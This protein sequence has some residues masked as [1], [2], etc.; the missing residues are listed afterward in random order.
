MLS[1]F[2]MLRLIA[3]IRIGMV[4]RLDRLSAVS[5]GGH[6][7]GWLRPGLW[8]AR[9]C[10]APVRSRRYL[11]LSP[12]T[13][14][15]LALIELGP[16]FIKFGQLLSTRV[17]LLDPKTINELSQL[18]DKVPAFANATA[19][20]IVEE[21]LQAPISELFAAFDQDTIASASIA[22]VYG[23]RLP[24]GDSV[25]VKVV[26][27]GIER[28]I[29]RDIK[30]MRRIAGLIERIWPPSRKLRLP[31]VVDNYHKTI[32]GELDME[33]EAASCS[34]LARNFADSSL[35]YVP[36]IHWKW[37]GPRVLTQER[38]DGIAVND[39]AT[40]DKLGISRK[41]L[42]AKGVEIFFTQVFD[43]SF[44]HADMHPG[45]IFVMRD[46]AA[47]PRYVGVDFGIMGSLSDEDQYYLAMN[48]LAFFNRDYRRVARLHV[49]CG[50]VSPDTRVEELETAVRT[51]CEPIFSLPIKEISFGKIITR[52]FQTAREFNMEVQPQLILLQKT[53]FHIEGL[54][55]QLYPDLDLWATAKPFLERWI[56]RRAGYKR[57]I[58]QLRQQAPDWIETL[59]RIPYIIND[60]NEQLRQLPLL[61]AAR[62]QELVKLRNM[63]KNNNR[64]LLAL[65]L[66]FGCVLSIIGFF[67]G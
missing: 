12:H 61:L 25:V 55:R 26:R 62:Q 10:L 15:R 65:L 20:A 59:P 52:L 43:H 14:L 38:I 8:T 32:I 17:D 29:I 19:R 40:M 63:Q 49:E 41:V 45:N 64:L 3:I 4:Y 31:E 35:L 50:W 51:V 6:K 36:S 42:A 5:R 27:P 44:F 58:E 23:A 30:L 47:D 46:S 11:E 67:A 48:L 56:R 53:L 28:V 66:L 60:A 7:F 33:R 39:I 16:I 9:N 21:D 24:G 13:C 57:L 2:S 1:P 18:Q 22:Q 37:C 34:Q 54:G